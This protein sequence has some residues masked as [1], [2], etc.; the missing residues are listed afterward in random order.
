MCAR[1][2]GGLQAKRSAEENFLIPNKAHSNL[3]SQASPDATRFPRQT[4]PTPRS[5]LCEAE[6][7]QQHNRLDAS[8]PLLSAYG[9]QHVERRLDH[10]ASAPA[11]MAIAVP[12][13]S[14]M[15]AVAH[16]GAAHDEIRTATVLA[17]YNRLRG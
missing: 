14:G 3:A 7:L 4:F 9:N 17:R 12:D 10:L 13:L 2:G 8:Y 16:V 5:F 11:D 6:T 1:S 15:Y